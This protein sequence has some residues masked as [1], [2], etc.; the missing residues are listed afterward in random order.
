MDAEAERLYEAHVARYG[1][2]TVVAN[3][4][5]ALKRDIAN[6]EEEIVRLDNAL[7]AAQEHETDGDA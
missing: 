7:V 4:V 1:I 2:A 3:Y 6:A 5:L